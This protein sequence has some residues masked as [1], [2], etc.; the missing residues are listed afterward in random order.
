[1]RGFVPGYSGG[2]APDFHGIPLLSP[3]ARLRRKDNLMPKKIK[4]QNAEFKIKKLAL[5]K[6][7]IK[8]MLFSLFVFLN[9]A[10]VFFFPSTP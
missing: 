3:G 4:I 7:Q 6:T 2:P 10:F 9:F 8:K 1:L 5:Q